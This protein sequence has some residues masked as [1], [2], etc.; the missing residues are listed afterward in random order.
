MAGFSGLPSSSSSSSNATWSGV[1][2]VKGPRWARMPL[3][4]I[5]MLGLQIVWSV[6]MGY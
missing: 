3:L 5:G 2:R 1:A 6:E 4:T